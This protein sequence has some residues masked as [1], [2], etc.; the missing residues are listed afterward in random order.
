MEINDDRIIDIIVSTV[1][2]TM[3]ILTFLFIFLKIGNVINW[4]WWIILSPFLIT[5]LLGFLFI[6]VILIIIYV[7][8]KFK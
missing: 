3:I 8:S 2:I 4:E 5:L 6:I 1:P 7:E